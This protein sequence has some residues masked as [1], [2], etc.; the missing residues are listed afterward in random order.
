M[1]KR[2]VHTG[3]W[4]SGT[5][6]GQIPEAAHTFR[7]AANSNEFQLTIGETTFGG[8]SQLSKQPGAVIDYGSLIWTTLQRARNVS[9]AIT[10]MADLVSQHGYASDGESFS[11]ADPNEIWIMEMIGKGPNATGAVWAA[12]RIPDGYVSGHANQARIRSFVG[13]KDCRWAPDVVSFA[14]DQ[15]LYPA[16]GKPEDFSFSD[17]YDPVSFTGRR[18]AELR[19]W[20]FFRQVAEDE[21][22]GDKYLAYVTGLDPAAATD[23]M[24]LWIKPRAKVSL[25]DTMWFMR[26]HYEDTPFDMRQDVGAGAFGA[27]V[28]VRPLDWQYGAS[29]Y[30][31][32]RPIGVQQT[33]WHFVAQMRSWLPDPVGG[34]VWFGVDDTAHSHHIPVYVGAAAV[35]KKWSD[36]GIQHVDDEGLGLKVDFDKA[37]WV[38]N[39]VA[40]LVYGRYEDAHPVVAQRIAQTEAGYFKAVARIDA[41]A[42]KL[43]A[44]EAEALLTEFTVATG[45]KAVSDW[46]ELWK[47]LFFRFRDFFTVTP[48]AQTRADSNINNSNNNN[49]NN[50][51]NDQKKPDYPW[52]SVNQGGYSARWAKKIVAETGARYRVPDDQGSG[53]GDSGHDARKRRILGL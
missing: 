38:F 34:I 22:F 36:A 4:D 1:N 40:N 49:N 28:R 37:F 7:V 51:N 26:A 13:K 18:L 46:L 2:C 3:D 48:P 5:Y 12:C 47:D 42:A 50:N 45:D 52:A 41:K 39:M 6:L 9:E 31:N 20:E 25:N 17:T 19:V 21:G 53:L 27:A 29:Q 11:I 23:R 35:S 14:K 32:E 8:L 15:G 44:K 10:V 43:G 24:P 30:H 33:G 16:N